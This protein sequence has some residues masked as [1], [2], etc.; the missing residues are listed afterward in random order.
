MTKRIA[1]AA[2]A[3]ALAC[4]A[5]RS[6]VGIYD[7][8]RA[9]VYGPVGGLPSLVG[10]AFRTAAV[11]AIL[12]HSALCVACCWGARCITCAIGRYGRLQL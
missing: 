12:A 3:L 6:A 7:A 10:H 4:I 8:T 11:L 1:A 9:L 5:V 2:V